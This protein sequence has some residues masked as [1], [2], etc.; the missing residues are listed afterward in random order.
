MS[1]NLIGRPQRSFPKQRLLQVARGGSGAGQSRKDQALSGELIEPRSGS[2][3][4]GEA[5]DSGDGG[6][7]AVDRG[8]AQDPAFEDGL[9]LEL[10]EGLDV[11]NGGREEG[12]F[13]RGEGDRGGGSSPWCS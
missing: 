6:G 3:E 10:G 5:P 7:E 12:D 13:E 4:G 1:P 9:P 2:K 8:G 11:E